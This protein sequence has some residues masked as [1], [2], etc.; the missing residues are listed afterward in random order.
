MDDDGALVGMVTRTD[1]LRQHNFYRDS[2]EPIPELLVPLRGP[3]P[4][5]KNTT[6]AAMAEA[7]KENQHLL[8]IEDDL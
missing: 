6:V 5:Q 3:A 4:T 8:V 1:V 7:L 2:R